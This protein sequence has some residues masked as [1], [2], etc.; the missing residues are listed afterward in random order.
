MFRSVSRHGHAGRTR[1]GDRAVVLIIKRAVELAGY[2]PRQYSGHSLRSGLATSAAQAGRSERAIMA[3]TGHLSEK[4]VRRYIRDGSLF[5][6][7]VVEG[8]L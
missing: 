2:D 6:E 3:Q 4:M 8:L 7:N 5:T 1:L